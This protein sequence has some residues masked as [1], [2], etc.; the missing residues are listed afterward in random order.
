VYHGSSAWDHGNAS[1][2]IHAVR[3]QV[4]YDAEVGFH[5]VDD[6]S[7]V[8]HQ[9]RVT[10]QSAIEDACVGERAPTSAWPVQ[11]VEGAELVI[12]V[13]LMVTAYGRT[14][15]QGDVRRVELGIAGSVVQAQGQ[16]VD[17]GLA[18]VRSGVGDS[19]PAPSPC[20]QGHSRQCPAAGK[21]GEAV[22]HGRITEHI[23]IDFA[24]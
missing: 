13:G 1:P 17:I 19:V 12:D 24:D 2:G 8:G 15:R 16:P 3:T 6:C 11:G 7:G 4:L 20:G 14:Q 18:Q 23:G 10:G 22:A 9:R 5:P 21:K